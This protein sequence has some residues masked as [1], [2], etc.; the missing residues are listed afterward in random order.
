MHRK[1]FRQLLVVAVMLSMVLGQGTWALAGTTGTLNGLVTDSG[2]GAP[3]A[4]AHV[5]VTS[6]SQTATS[7][8]DGSGHFTFVSLIPDTYTV[9]VLRDGYDPASLAG[10]TVFADQAFSVNV[11]TQKSLRTIAKVTARAASDLVKSGTTADIYSVSAA[12]QKA[13]ATLGGGGGLN[14]AYSAVASVPGVFV[15]AGQ[16]GEYQS[17]FVRGG[18]YTQ[19]GYEFDGVPIQRAFDQYPGAS[20]SN[21]GQQELQVY[22]GTAPVNAGSTALAGFVNQVIK[23]GT[24]PG[25]GSVGMGVSA[26]YYYHQM[27]VEAGGASPNRNFSYY[28]GFDGYNQ[29]FVYEDGSQFTQNWGSPIN[30]L[31][32]DCAATFAN[33][34]G[35]CYS[36]SGG[37][38]P[39]GI[40][41]G[42]VFFGVGSDVASRDAV[43]NFHFALPHKNDGGRDDIQ[44]LYTTDYVRTGFADNL[45][46]MGALKSDFV[47]GTITT[48]NGVT[49][50]CTNA[51]LAANTPCS[52]F[53]Y[54]SGFVDRYY[55]KIAY[56]GQLGTAL[57][58]ADLS[59][60]QI[61]FFANSPT[62]RKY[63]TA[64]SPVFI[65]PNE[66]DSY[67]QNGAIFKAQYQH[68]M[69]SNAFLRLY[70]YTTYSDWLQYGVNSQPLVSGTNFGAISSD[71]KLGSHTRG[72]A[73][74]FTDQISPQ[75]LLNLD[76]SYTTANTF[77]FNNAAITTSTSTL[78][79]GSTTVAFLVDS[80]NPMSGIC[81][82]ATGVGTATVATDCGNPS[83]T[84]NVPSR[85]INP[86]TPS[87]LTGG[88]AGGSLGTLC[89]AATKD[90]TVANVGTYVC[91]G[92]PCEYFTVA[93][94][95]NASYNTVVPKFAAISLQD[96]WRP[97]DKLLFTLGLRYDDF[98]Y[99]LPDTT[100][101]AARAFWT[102]YYNSFWCYNSVQQAT[103]ELPK[104][105]APNSCATSLGTGWTQVAT[106]PTTA[107][108]NDYP[109]LQ[110]RFGLTYTL[111]ANNVIRFSAGKTAQPASSAFQQYDYISPNFFYPNSTN[112]LF[113][114]LGYTTPR[115]VVYPEE[116][117]NYD[118]SWEHAFRGTD[119]SF[120][121]TPY[122]RTTKNELSTV[123]LDPQTSFVSSVNVGQK[124]VKGL[125]FEFRKGDVNK[126]GWFGQLS[127][128]YTYAR[129]KF[130][131]L[132]NGRSVVDGLNLS[133]QQ[134]NRQTSFC[135][136]NPNDARCNAP[137]AA[138]IAPGA[139]CYKTDGS[140]D[141]A[142]AA[143]S[144]ANPYWNAPV[145]N[146][147]DPNGQYAVYNTMAGSRFV[148]G[149]N[150]SYVVPHVLALI[151]NYKHDK[152]NITPTFQL[153]AGGEYGRPT[154]VVG[155]NPATCSATLAGSTAND[156]RYPNGAAGGSPYNAAYCSGTLLT[157]DPFTGRFDNYGQFKEPNIFYGNLSLSYD[158]S[159]KI[160]ARLDLVNVVAKCF[161]G[162]GVAWKVSGSAGCNYGPGGW[163]VNNFYNPGDKLDP[164]VKYPYNP[165]FGSVFQSSS[166]GQANPFQAYFSVNVKL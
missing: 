120:K 127:Y 132:P 16:K 10:V 36:N 74:N 32:H 125:E 20:L 43:M 107:N 139:P 89:R 6:A 57:T 24:Y 102:N 99:V 165:N 160:T 97:T 76:L 159:P 166:G 15:P 86:Q 118:A 13:A 46:A 90:P 41:H 148:S 28:A 54:G 137:G 45:N 144:V 114:G 49:P 150:Q 104:N 51:L 145:Q 31:A 81:Y 98:K 95:F 52:I 69:G 105:K 12:T 116:S 140:P 93:N 117:Y 25:F 151:L 38:M 122:I 87:Q 11:S 22:T 94:Q 3:I 9:S 7:S 136:S 113:Y 18:N 73:L 110:P 75:H 71:Y 17:I 66:R 149:S 48:A 35:G 59:N 68:N 108:V 92:H 67:Q 58:T 80:T 153:L 77:R 27:S 72:A 33:P 29:T 96:S 23:T 19:V 91:N 131:K 1:L 100:G 40:E 56:S 88:C 123:L 50:A 121:L 63:S 147:F 44:L 103:K 106:T 129:E 64:A 155:V 112:Q 2:S 61:A 158:V 161:G 53:Q 8:T 42:P 65:D 83:G 78:A 163:Y 84:T 142:C 154:Q 82:S 62:N 152:F 138:Q 30:L 34:T 157:P 60:T 124:N 162:S 21:L 70:G 126:N 4:N 85:I 5:T 115:H 164:L 55:D 109:E 119:M 135:A 47:N 37:L 133:I 130:T 26:P 101:G 143:Q 156:P 146:L 141:P 128:T 14:N 111:D 134:Y 79:A 39:N